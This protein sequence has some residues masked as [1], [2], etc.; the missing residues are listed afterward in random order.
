L[1]LGLAAVASP[2]LAL[3]FEDA[4]DDQLQETAP[5]SAS[6][7]Q[8]A[9]P[10]PSPEPPRLRLHIDGAIA[11][12]YGE[13]WMRWSGG[14][15]EYASCAT[16]QACGFTL[17]LAA[18]ADVSLSRHVSLGLRARWLVGG[19]QWNEV[20]GRSLSVVE[21]LFVP[22]VS[23]PW[24]WRWPRGGLR[25]Y[26]ALPVGPAWSFLSRT[27]SRAVHEEWDSRIGLSVGLALGMEFYLS[28][29]W[30][31][32]VETSYQAHFLSGNVTQTPVDEPS[33]EVT[34]PVT[35]KQGM[36]LLTLGLLLPLDR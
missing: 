5:A 13:A 24:K 36:L 1:A 30:G 9:A 19:S 20:Q 16:G 21:I 8:T 23:L 11:H 27:W 2:A 3:D 35:A 31:W 12:F 28:R 14:E 10:L 25:P 22:Q 7:A 33:A 26:L 15:T 4:S 6:A 29:R 17:A 32:L 18:G 34:T